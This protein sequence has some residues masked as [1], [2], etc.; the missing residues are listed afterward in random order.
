MKNEEKI[1]E[2]LTNMNER[3]SNIEG[4]ISNVNV[5]LDEL[6]LEVK[7]T[8][9]MT[10]A[11]REQLV[12]LTEEITGIK[13]NQKETKEELERKIS[14]LDQKIEGYQIINEGVHRDIINIII[15]GRNSISTKV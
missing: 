12:F 13:I 3:L 10:N 6:T 7:E 5:R 15:K 11:N 4:E 9:K 1:M 14:E 2:L 8:K